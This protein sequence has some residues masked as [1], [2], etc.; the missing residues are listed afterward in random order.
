MSSIVPFP[1]FFCEDYDWPWSEDEGVLRALIMYVL[2]L[3]L[4][5]ERRKPLVNRRTLGARGYI[6]S[7][8]IVITYL[9]TF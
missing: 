5:P 1:S 6:I 4:P 7:G 2:D 9:G 8:Y 3:V